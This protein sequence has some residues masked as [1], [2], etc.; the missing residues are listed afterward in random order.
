[1]DPNWK[2]VCR[3]DVHSRRSPLQFVVDDSEVLNIGR[4]AEFHGLNRDYGYNGVLP[5]NAP[6]PEVV[7]IPERAKHGTTFQ[8]V[9]E[10]VGNGSD[11]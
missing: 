1:V 8:H 11:E 7:Y 6:E 3:V 4:D 5:E 10:N 9:V 2:V